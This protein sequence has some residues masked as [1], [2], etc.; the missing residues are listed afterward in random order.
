MNELTARFMTAAGEAPESVAQAT[1]STHVRIERALD[2][3]YLTRPLFLT[4]AQRDLIR[5]PLAELTALLWS[6]PE[7]TGA[8]LDGFAAMCG[9]SPRQREAVLRTEDGVRFE[10][11]RA[12]LFWTGDRFQV[13]EMNLTS[14]TGGTDVGEVCRAMLHMPEVSAFVAREGLGYV[15]PMPRLA[16]V[17]RAACERAGAGDRPRIVLAYWPDG[18]APTKRTIHLVAAMLADRGL[19][20]IACGLDELRHV[21]DAVVLDG[22]PVDVVHRF[23]VIEDVD[24]PGGWDLV[25]PLLRAHERGRIRV[26]APFSAELCGSKAALALLWQPSVR[27]R[28]SERERALVADLVPWTGRL[29]PAVTTED[30]T[31]VPAVDHC[32]RHRADLVLKPA[33]LQGGAGVVMG[34]QTTDAEWSA[35]VESGLRAD[36]VV[37]RHVAAAPETFLEGWPRRPVRRTVNL[38]VHVIGGGYAGLVARAARAD[39]PGIVSL[40]LGGALLGCCFEPVAAAPD[41]GSPSG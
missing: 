34:N 39:A 9:A 19:D 20:V 40:G 33:M 16:A 37:Q 8:G 6:L 32:R 26:V 41:S 23:F 27:D 21:D 10:V 11:G 13:L 25:E 35:A 7:R 14:A 1:W 17:L 2:R 36:Y 5:G 15:D 12:D 18:A 30:G 4:A 3:G 29:R 24:V 28:L 38:G 31:T 22:R